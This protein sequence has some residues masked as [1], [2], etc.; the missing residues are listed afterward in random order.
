MKTS[1]LPGIPFIIACIFI[2]AP[3]NS[4]KS[5]NYQSVGTHLEEISIFL[6]GF[7]SN[8]TQSN[9]EYDF[10]FRNKI[11]SLQECTIDKT[12]PDLQGLHC[13]QPC[14]KSETKARRAKKLQF[15]QEAA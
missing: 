8:S 10:L 7:E 15:T 2:S 1:M 4:Q 3:G 9:Y 14:V 12:N 13:D 11:N 6:G 5:I